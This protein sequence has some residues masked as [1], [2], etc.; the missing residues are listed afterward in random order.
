MT[1]KKAES[2]AGG[3]SS[4]VPPVTVSRDAL[5]ERGSDHRFRQL[6]YD[7]EHLGELLDKSRSHLAAEVGLTPPQYNI[8][9]VIAEHQQVHGI[10]VVEI[11]KNLH[12]SG[13]FV[14]T[15]ANRL[16]AIGMAEKIPN[17]SDGRSIL[18]KLT[19]RGCVEIERI[20]P[21]IRAFNDAFFASMSPISFEQFSTTVAELIDTG[22]RALFEAKATRKGR[23]TSARRAAIRTPG[24]S[25]SVRSAK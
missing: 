1:K 7:L 22:E 12:V 4:F 23:A 21:N 18:L 13:A 15:Q 2:E 11:A 16:V 8:L 17:P 3:T 24:R 20:A 10:S 25:A 9:M 19:R 14:T 6:L 5:L